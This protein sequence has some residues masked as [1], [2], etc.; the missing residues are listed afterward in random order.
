MVLLRSA[1]RARP[2]RS[3]GDKKFAS[4]TP[5]P[6]D[7]THLTTASL[8]R[9]ALSPFPQRLR[10]DHPSQQPPALYRNNRRD[11]SPS[12]VRTR[13]RPFGAVLIP[14]TGS[15]GS[16]SERVGETPRQPHPSPARANQGSLG[17]E[18]DDDRETAPKPVFKRRHAQ[19]LPICIFSPSS[20]CP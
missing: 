16:A 10:I 5:H 19:Y 2:D 9:P 8:S 11:G 12:R 4:A 14:I 13:Y 3:G 18:Q 7:I 15:D 17:A 1:E 20:S 6:S